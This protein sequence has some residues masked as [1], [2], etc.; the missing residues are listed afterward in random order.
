MDH[1]TNRSGNLDIQALRGNGWWQTLNIMKVMDHTWGDT[2]EASHSAIIA[3]L[4]SPSGRFW[5]KPNAVRYGFSTAIT[6]SGEVLTRSN[7]PLIVLFSGVSISRDKLGAGVVWCDTT[8]F[9]LAFGK[10]EL[11][12]W[13]AFFCWAISSFILASLISRS[14]ISAS[15][16]SS[17]SKFW[18]KEGS[19]D[20]VSKLRSEPLA[21]G[22][23]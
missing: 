18:V 2:I 23:T 10:G 20:M 22:N 21:F 3:D 13:L 15:L 9:G 17:P 1:E 5:M 16:S 6:P 4:H 8:A 19:V 11:T 12:F 7:S 14:L